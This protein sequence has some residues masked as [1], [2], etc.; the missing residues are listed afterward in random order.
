MK[1]HSTGS[2]KV[3]N[4]DLISGV[5][6]QIIP[7]N[8]PLAMQ[9]WKWGPLL[10]TGCTSVL[11]TAEQTPLSALFIAELAKEV[12]IPVLHKLSMKY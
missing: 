8:F 9:S 2:F 12:G 6:G 10:A 1:H 7:W 5:C 3:F 11:K 4:F